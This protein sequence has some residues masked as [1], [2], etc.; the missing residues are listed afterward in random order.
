MFY[1]LSHIGS[2][3]Y[4][5]KEY[6]TDF[7]FPPHM[8]QCFEFITVLSGELKVTVDAAEYTIQKGE[9]LLLFPNQIHSLHSTHCQHMLCIFSPKLIA[10]Y[11]SKVS[12]KLPS[13]NLFTPDPS[14]IH[15]IDCLTDT[16]STLE[17]K[18]LLYL[19]CDQ[20]NRNAAYQTKSHDKNNLLAAVFAF[21]EENYNSNCGLMDLAKQIGYD[22]SYISRYFKKNVGIS[23]NEYVNI[24]RLNNAC[25]LLTNTDN[26]IL[27]C[28]M[29]SGYT[30]LRSFNRNFKEQFQVS[31]SEY[32]K[33]RRN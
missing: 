13:G 31:P 12:Q 20:F 33:S 9:A 11:A 32:T 29:E 18:G 27:Q 16:A 25:Y 2:S 30:S 24:Y 14:L 3:D 10:A 5:R 4:F 21:I 19:L 28:A 7:T 17:K 1:Q 15:A 8:H 6:G 22:Y 26:T 23:F